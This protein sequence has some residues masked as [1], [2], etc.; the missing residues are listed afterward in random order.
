MKGNGKPYRL[1]ERQAKFVRGV[2]S[3]KTAT[4]A[5]KDAGY[6]REYADRQAKQ[7]LEKPQV[8]QHLADLN[9][10]IASPEIADAASRQTWWTTVMNDTSQDI[11]ARLKASELLGKAQGDFIER[12][13]LSTKDDLP[14]KF[15]LDL[16]AASMARLHE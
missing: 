3:G 12:R 6:G 5:A 10:K 13:E 8:K 15:K 2:A 11:K 4:Q 14:I 1:T 16:G 9:Q 7:L